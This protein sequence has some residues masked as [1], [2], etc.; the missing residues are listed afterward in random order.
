MSSSDEKSQEAFDEKQPTRKPSSA[1]VLV[2]G[3]KSPPHPCQESGQDSP[4]PHN[5]DLPEYK[6]QVQDA[7][8]P[9]KL[10]SS[11]APE[12]PL[13]SSY[14]DG[15]AGRE[16]RLCLEPAVQARKEGSPGPTFKEQVQ[17]GLSTRD[18]P[19]GSDDVE[20][21]F[22]E[23]DTAR[24]QIS[25]ASIA[26]H[27]LQRPRAIQH[28]AFAVYGNHRAVLRERDDAVH[29]TLAQV[30]QSQDVEADLPVAHL[31]ES[32]DEGQDKKQHCVLISCLTI[33]LVFGAVLASVCGSGLCSSQN[34]P[35]D[36]TQATPTPSPMKKYRSL[37]STEELYQAVNI[38][39][40]S[41]TED[42]KNSIVSQTCGYPIGTWDVS[43]IKDFSYV[44]VPV[45]V[46]GS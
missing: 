31:V 34:E 18:T 26:D 14:P 4:S 1:G 32:K 10:A 23:D 24:N 30:S 19:Q 38:Y 9:T 15:E 36:P 46:R 43:Q 13:V 29:S 35:E 8:P 27:P 33:I 17:P 3:N 2:G 25:P 22:V 28:G 44:F 20:Q 40:L 39:L 45:G 5:K 41:Q 37:T 21:E 12:L 11:E 42:P 7:V 16:E 6:D